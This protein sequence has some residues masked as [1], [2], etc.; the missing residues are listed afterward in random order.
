MLSSQD[1][2]HPQPEGGMV[3]RQRAAPAVSAEDRRRGVVA[4][5]QPDPDN[6]RNHESVTRNELARRLAILKAYDFAGE[7]DARRRY[8]A[9]VYF[10][11][12]DTIIGR[13]RAAALGIRDADDLFGAVVPRPFM[14]VKTI[15]H[16]LV[17][18][19]SRAPQGWCR[20]FSDAV[21]DVVLDGYA[22]FAPPDLRRA[23]E[24]LLSR[25]P[26]RVKRATGTGG[27]GQ[28]VVGH[29]DEVEDLLAQIE[30]EEL[31]RLGIV[32]EQNLAEVVT[33]SVGQVRVAGLTAS[34]HG[35]QRLTTN[36]RGAE[37]YGGSTLAFVRGDFDVLL[38]GQG[39]CPDARRAV[40]LARVYDAAA[41]R[42]L[43]GMIASRRNYDVAIGTD[44]EGRNRGGVLEAS[45]R[46]GGASGAEVAALLAF[47]EDPDLFTIRASSIECYGACPPPPA[48]A[49]VYFRAE[50]HRVGML[51]KYTVLERDAHS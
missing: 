32:V 41:A 24:A 18:R 13:N 20:G 9:P 39:L 2:I 40:D 45:W 6:A 5:L 50:D 38:A 14:A 35:K 3:E 43:V 23:A 7:F 26:V 46:M 25:G 37:V 34:Y 31:R 15:S 10:L 21:R 19:A 29:R 27:T 11:P 42:H 12:A 1:S 51:T 47:R 8:G 48:H 44:V 17:D 4:T 33:H 49:T 22:A 16:P 36:N 28:R 30:G